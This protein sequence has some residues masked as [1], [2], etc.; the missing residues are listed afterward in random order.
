MLVWLANEYLNLIKL[1]Q[2][3][4]LILLSLVVGL[5][6][7]L[8]AQS[9][10]NYTEVMRSALKTEKKAIIAEV[11]T[12]TDEEGVAFWPLYNEYQEKLYISNTKYLGIINDFVAKI[13]VLS[14]DDAI[15]LMNRLNAYDAEV[16]KL[17]KSYI[18][19]FKKVLPATKVLR[20]VQAE[21]KIDVLVNFEIANS[22][23]LLDN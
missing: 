1:K 11:M 7:S 9:Q 23:P 13:N 2:M 10:D 20:Y 21:N 12:F 3:K 5:S 6:I 18:K 14:E 22:I 17:R 16:L 15:D 8:F 19:K 4:K